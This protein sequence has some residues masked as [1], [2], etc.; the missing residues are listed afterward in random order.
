MIVHP[1]LSRSDL[2][3]DLENN[4]ELGTGLELLPDNTFLF[5]GRRGERVMEKKAQIGISV[6]GFSALLLVF[7][8]HLIV[9]ARRKDFD[10]K[11][12][13]DLYVLMLG[14]SVIIGFVIVI[15]LLSISVKLRT[16]M[17][18]SMLSFGLE[19]SADVMREYYGIDEWL[20]GKKQHD[21]NGEVRFEARDWFY[22]H[23][24]YDYKKK[25]KR[26]SSPV[27]IFK[28]CLH[29][30]PVLCL[31]LGMAIAFRLMD[32]VSPGV[33][34]VLI[35]IMAFTFVGTMFA[36]HLNEALYYLT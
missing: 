33:A 17:G 16:L 4:V 27:T 15:V 28:K 20:K 9:S 18:N 25:R 35:A 22:S 36:L 34:I 31:S 5:M 14:I 32:A 7:C 23:S 6:A 30:F 8:I 2:T 3:F 29:L 24:K 12:L 11:S 13:F 19:E 10:F 21:R 1:S 26:M